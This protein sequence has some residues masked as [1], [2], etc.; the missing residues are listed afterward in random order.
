MFLS[1]LVTACS[2][3]AF[4]SSSF[5]LLEKGGDVDFAKAPES[6]SVP[7][8]TSSHEGGGSRIIVQIEAS[9]NSRWN[10]AVGKQLRCWS[11][12]KRSCLDIAEEET[13][14]ER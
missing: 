2:S 8:L 14:D 7:P 10:T 5:S 13:G 6:L 3:A 11:A 9:A 4:S 12:Q 1:F